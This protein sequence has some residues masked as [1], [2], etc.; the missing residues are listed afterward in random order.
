MPPSRVERKTG[1]SWK[2]A[3]IFGDTRGLY[4]K[5]TIPQP[6]T[7]YKFYSAYVHE[8]EHKSI[9]LI[10]TEHTKIESK[11]IEDYREFNWALLF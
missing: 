9:V 5:S 1:C 4:F 3:G 8:F 7:V 6:Q 11:N 10:I 2:Q